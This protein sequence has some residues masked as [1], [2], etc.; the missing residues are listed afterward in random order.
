MWVV[1]FRLPARSCGDDKFLSS[2]T[3]QRIWLPGFVLQS[4][5]I[6]GGY[7]TGRELVEFFLSSG[8]VGGLL[9]M[10]VATIL[11]SVVSALCFELA[12]LTQSYNYRSFFQQLLGRGWFL[13]ELAY[14][15]LGLLVL[16][17]VGAAAGEL[18]SA[19]LG[20]PSTVVTVIFMALVG[21][22]V[23][24]GSAMIEKALASW[25]ILLYVT[26]VTLVGCY[27][28]RYGNDLAANLGQ[29]PVGSEWLVKSVRYV[30]YNVAVIPVVLFCVNHMTSR[31]DAF[32]AGALAGPLVMAPAILFYLAMAAAYPAILDSA[33]PA[34]FL[35]QGLA[36]PWLMVIF[37]IVVFGTLVATGT[38]FIHAVNERIDEAYR[39]K[40]KEMSHW[41]RVAIAF[42]ALLL[43]VVLAGKFGLIG[44]IAKGYGTLTWVFIAVFVIPLC[45]VGV[46]KIRQGKASASPGS[47]P[48]SSSP[49]NHT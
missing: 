38:A 35:M 36:M 24:W 1:L 43:A 29:A 28:W 32:T 27:L 45:T 11:F 37:Y 30:G 17:V 3:F 19:H 20:I 13:F 7:A 10:L 2:S 14:F 15:V 31:R 33:V 4:V 47:S 5:V 12:R 23:F 41:Q 49:P 16:A 40:G 6:G 21:L 26:Y 34:D 18:T 9:G 25:A 8:P 22:L 39:E 48:G 42:I 46:W 44:L